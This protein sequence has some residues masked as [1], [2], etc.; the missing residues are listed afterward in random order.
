[1]RNETIRKRFHCHE[2]GA[3]F[4]KTMSIYMLDDPFCP[5][6]D[7]DFVEEL[8]GILQHNYNLPVSILAAPPRLGFSII[9][10]FG[11][12]SS[13][14]FEEDSFFANF[15][16]FFEDSD[17][18][19][20]MDQHIDFRANVESNYD[21]ERALRLAERLSLEQR[22]PAKKKPVAKKFALKLPVCKMEEK[23][24][25]K[26]ADGKLE[27][28]IC[29]ICCSNITLKEQFQLIPCG[30]MYHPKCI[31]P[32][33]EENNTCPVCRKEFPTEDTSKKSQGAV[34]Q[35]EERKITQPQARTR[36]TMGNTR[37]T[38]DNTR[39]VARKSLTEKRAT[40]GSKIYKAIA[41]G[42]ARGTRRGTIM[43]G[44]R[45]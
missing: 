30:H 19:D 27:T 5:N 16:S 2:C 3:S 44:R 26:G 42:T 17:F 1:M 35:Q 38:K 33:F 24:C 29:S 40:S 21:F 15:S 34:R 36:G 23:H 9:P 11:I 8:E 31:Q 14:L 25:K 12:P 22:Q 41:R 43:Q 13:D 20:I 10:S 37:G 32:W 6:C 4:M 28:P 18:I 7:G 39:R 45:V